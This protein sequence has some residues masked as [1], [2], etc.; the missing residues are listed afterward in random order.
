MMIKLIVLLGNHGREYAE[1]R[2]N[3]AWMMFDY[4]SIENSLNWQKKFKG[5][6]AATSNKRGKLYILKPYTFMNKS[7]ESVLAI[8]QFFKIDP[9][10]IL[11]VHDDLETAFGT[12]SFKTGGGLAG[13]NGLKS[14]AAQLGTNSFNRLKLGISRPKF[15]SVSSYVL[16]KFSSDE[17][18]VLPVYLEK[19]AQELD[20]MVEK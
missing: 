16:G 17:Q 2:H 7:G 1:T 12:F 19:M 11:V 15:G 10:E 4:S 13:H 18:A 6:Y 5:E 14:I 9:K 20:S 3:I 8:S